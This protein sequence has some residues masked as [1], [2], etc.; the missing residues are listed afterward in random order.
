[1]INTILRKVE[2]QEDHVI[3][4]TCDKCKKEIFTEDWVDIQE[5]HHIRFTGGYGS[6][7]GDESKV[8]C[9]FCQQCLKEIIGPYCRI[10]GEYL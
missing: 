8:E 4:V 10:N 9:D 3:S 1:M 2:T 5:M 7:F 6:V